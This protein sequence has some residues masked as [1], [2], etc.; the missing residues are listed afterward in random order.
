[1]EENLHGYFCRYPKVDGHSVGML[2]WTEIPHL[3]C[4]LEQLL[5]KSPPGLTLEVALR[6][7]IQQCC[8]QSDKQAKEHLTAY[9]SRIAIVQSRKLHRKLETLSDYQY[10]LVDVF[11]I[12]LLVACEPAKFFQGYKSNKYNVGDFAN[13]RMKTK[14]QEEL[15]KSLCLKDKQK[16]LRKAK[17]YWVLKNIAGNKG[18]QLKDAL[19]AFGYKGLELKRRVLAWQ[20]FDEVYVPA[21]GEK[22]EPPTQEKLE[23]M[24]DLYCRL[25]RKYSD[26]KDDNL[27]VNSHKIS[28]WLEECIKVL[29]KH[30]SQREVS[31][32]APLQT[33][34]E[35]E[36]TL[37]TKTAEKPYTYGGDAAEINYYRAASIDLEKSLNE[38]SSKLDKKQ[39]HLLILASGFEL[40]TTAIASILNCHQS[41]I[42]RQV[43]DIKKDWL[44]EQLEKL[45][46]KQRA[47]ELRAGEALDKKTSKSIN[48][49]WKIRES[50]FSSLI[51]QQ[52]E[53]GWQ[54]LKPPSPQLLEL[55]FTR[56]QEPVK[57]AKNLKLDVAEVEDKIA[58]AVGNLEGVLLQWTEQKLEQ[59]LVT[60]EPLNKKISE[61]VEQWLVVGSYSN[62]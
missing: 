25:S 58:E 19:V 44:I 14:I 21:K 28:Q 22:H 20:C 40:T 61:L 60:C 13:M 12:G 23:K 4:N 31:F 5:L 46:M 38:F 16:N 41:T 54:Q 15:F 6:D 27:Q 7:F 32:D 43:N 37:L 26:L 51:Y 30:N 10:S 24:A 8:H 9:L 17:K 52:F 55:R 45:R 62:Y 39:Y 34:A 56:Q 50:Y 33:D 53:Q 11:Q 2:R 57:I 35:I 48:E 3:K 42:F 29:Y 36:E 1:M 49:F 59:S 47:T 18:K